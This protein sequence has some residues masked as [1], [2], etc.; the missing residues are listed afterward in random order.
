MGEPNGMFRWDLP[1]VNGE[2]P[3]GY[4]EP[5]SSRAVAGFFTQPAVCSHMWMPTETGE[6]VDGQLLN[7]TKL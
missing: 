6:F 7:I 2:S 3:G 1:L 5:P 4:D